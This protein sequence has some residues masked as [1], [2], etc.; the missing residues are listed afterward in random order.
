[1]TADTVG[2]SNARMDRINK[3]VAKHVGD[4][5]LAGV[6]TLLCRRGTTVCLEARG[7]LDRERDVPMRTDAIF[8]IHSMTKVITAVALMVLYEQGHMQ[9]TDPAARFLRSF[10]EVKVWNDRQGSESGLVRPDRPV[11]VMDLLTHT[12]G[13]TYG[14]NEQ[15]PVEKMYREASLL[16]KPQPL[17]MLVDEL[18]KMPL[19]FQPGTQYRYSHGYDV[20]ARII[21]IASGDSYDEFLRKNLFEPLQM[22]DTGFYV[23]PEKADRLAAMYGTKDLFTDPESTMS[24][25]MEGAATS[26][27]HLIADPFNCAES[28]PT[29]NLRGGHGL[30]STAEDYCRFCRM[31]MGAGKL[32][33]ERVLSRKSVE[34]MTA[35][36]LPDE[37]LRQV[38]GPSI[39]HGIGFG[40]AV[41]RALGLLPLLGSVGEL[42]YNGASNTFFW[43]DPAEELIGIQMS[44]YMPPGVFPVAQD[45][46]VAA[47]Q[48]IDD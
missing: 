37:L 9:L 44:Q 8:R 15:G 17:S 4:E 2:M 11:T 45:F 47:Y 34:L 40:V 42:S 39:T 46:Q 7:L 10:S 6:V 12:S 31:L 13:L 27:S 1:M 5:K 30:V 26:G 22:H 43:I 41:R 24:E 21:E 23:V 33:G 35:N 18:A 32:D 16:T 3:A 36:H 48:A 29:T 20:I 38:Y 14:I 19:A 25:W 28:K